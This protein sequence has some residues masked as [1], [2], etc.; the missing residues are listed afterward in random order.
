MKRLGILH[1]FDSVPRVGLG[2]KKIGG[3]IDRD[4]QSWRG[5]CIVQGDA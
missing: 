2:D 3:C 5:C 1:V 4:T